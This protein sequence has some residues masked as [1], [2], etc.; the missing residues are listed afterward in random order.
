MNYR[1]KKKVKKRHSGLLFD[2][3]TGIGVKPKNYRE[4]KMNSRMLHEFIV[5]NDRSYFTEYNYRLKR[6]RSYRK[7]YAKAAID[8]INKSEKEGD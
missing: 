6:R 1:I 3:F 7:D 5:A 4:R 2:P 8:K